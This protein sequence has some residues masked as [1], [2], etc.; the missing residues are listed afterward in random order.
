MLG[1][2]L[3]ITPASSAVESDADRIRRNDKSLTYFVIRRD[4]YKSQT[5]EILDAL[6]INTVVKSVTIFEESDNLYRTKKSLYSCL[7]Q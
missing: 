3:T 1:H 5:V 6:K 4:D 7:K 2:R